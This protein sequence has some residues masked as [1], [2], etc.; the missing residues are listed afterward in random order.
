[1]RRV[2]VELADDDLFEIKA[3]FP[4]ADTAEENE[5]IAKFIWERLG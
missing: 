3:I 4:M 1:M 5:Q 2:I